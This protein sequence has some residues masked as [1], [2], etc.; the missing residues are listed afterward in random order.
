MKL[1][2]DDGVLYDGDGCLVVSDPVDGYVWLESIIRG[3]NFLVLVQDC[4]FVYRSAYQIGDEVS[5]P[6][7][8]FGRVLDIQDRAYLVNKEWYLATDLTLA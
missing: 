5:T 7:G 4:K 1:R 3:V 2:I 8:E 6:S